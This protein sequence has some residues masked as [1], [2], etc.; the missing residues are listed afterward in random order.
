MLSL[1]SANLVDI[2]FN[3]SRK[4]N[5]SL[6]YNKKI[7]SCECHELFIRKIII[8][9]ILKKGFVLFEGFVINIF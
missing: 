6:E 8:V 9:K 4:L 7:M 5:S 2:R 3:N 1:C